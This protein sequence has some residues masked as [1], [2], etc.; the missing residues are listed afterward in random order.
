MNPFFMAICGCRPATKA[1]NPKVLPVANLTEL[2][3]AISSGMPSGEQFPFHGAVRVDTAG[4]PP[5]FT[6]NL[7]SGY[8]RLLASK[9]EFARLLGRSPLFGISLGYFHLVADG[10]IQLSSG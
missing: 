10:F 8:T 4:I 5:K 9:T 1:Q 7:D 6:L 2:S 3:Y